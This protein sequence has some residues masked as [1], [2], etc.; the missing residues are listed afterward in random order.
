MY[1]K[2]DAKQVS[3]NEKTNS[4]WPVKLTDVVFLNALEMIVREGSNSQIK[5]FNIYGHR[6]DLDLIDLKRLL[7]FS[8]MA[9]NAKKKVVPNSIV[10]KVLVE[11][12]IEQEL[13]HDDKIDIEENYV[14]K[15][16]DIKRKVLQYEI[17]V[18]NNEKY[19]I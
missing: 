5:E 12:I 2:F 18:L 6:K 8:E 9:V 1:N 13:E 3:Q 7:S 11:I 15:Q 14:I 17:N 19:E 10:D 16:T 4:K